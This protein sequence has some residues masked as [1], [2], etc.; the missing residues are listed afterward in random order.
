VVGFALGL[1]EGSDDGEVVGT[2][3]VGSTDG[4]IGGVPEGDIEEPEA[5][6]SLGYTVGLCDGS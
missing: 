1:T 4:L 3:V 5:G 6:T 2:N